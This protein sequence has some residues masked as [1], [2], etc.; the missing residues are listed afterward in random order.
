[1]RLRV[2]KPPSPEFIPLTFKVCTLGNLHHPNL[3]RD[4]PP[5]QPQIKKSVMFSPPTLL[6]LGGLLCL[7]VDD[8][9]QIQNLKS[10]IKNGS[11]QVIRTVVSRQK[12][13]LDLRRL[14]VRFQ[15]FLAAALV[16]LGIK[17]LLRT[18]VT[19]AP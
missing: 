16:V 15:L 4:C 3:H 18:A 2:R 5:R 10:K 1:M 19:V 13:H 8:I 9:I 6:V 17:L 14:I 7:L 12:T 11:F